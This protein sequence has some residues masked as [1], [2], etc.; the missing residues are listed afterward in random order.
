VGTNANLNLQ[1][2]GTG[3][4]QI[5]GFPAASKVAVP[6]DLLQGGKPGQ[7]AADST[8]MTVYTGDGTTHA[9]SGVVTGVTAANPAHL[10]KPLSLWSGTKAQYDAIATKSATTI[11]VVTTAAA[12]LEGAVDGLT[13]GVDTGQISSEE[14]ALES[15]QNTLGAVQT[16][17]IV[18]DPAVAKTATTK[19]TRKK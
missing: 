11:Y 10:G 13:S 18:V 15:A 1:P 14:T 19:T 6:A 5:S 4:V 2:T 9:W 12:T 3:L 16:G 8:G 7:F 17:D